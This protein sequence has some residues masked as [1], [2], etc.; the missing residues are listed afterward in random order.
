M[1]P[2]CVAGSLAEK[3]AQRRCKSG[4]VHHNANGHFCLDVFGDVAVLIMKSKFSGANTIHASSVQIIDPSRLDT[5]PS[6][7]LAACRKTR[8]GILKES[9]LMRLPPALL[10]VPRHSSWTHLV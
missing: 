2:R 3:S 4:D 10:T 7:M 1:S 9:P 5:A 8:R 6:I